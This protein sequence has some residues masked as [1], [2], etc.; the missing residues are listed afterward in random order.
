MSLSVSMTRPHK[1]LLGP[2]D[3]ALCSLSFGCCCN[4]WPSCPSS[5]AASQSRAAFRFLA[6]LRE[7]ASNACSAAAR[8]SGTNPVA[9][10]GSGRG[11]VRH[12]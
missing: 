12:A 7:I 4:K 11:A 2:P 8:K 9:G 3:G 6:S 10:K 1:E 5:R